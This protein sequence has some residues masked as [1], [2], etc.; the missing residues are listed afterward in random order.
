MRPQV[1]AGLI[2]SFFFLLLLLLLLLLLP[3]FHRITHHN[4]A[5]FHQNRPCPPLL[6]CN[7]RI[8]L[9]LAPCIH[10]A[11]APAVAWTFFIKQP[12]ANNAAIQVSLATTHRF[13]LMGIYTPPSAIVYAC[14]PCIW[15][16]PTCMHYLMLRKFWSLKAIF[17]ILTSFTWIAALP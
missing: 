15:S 1:H 3:Q 2:L 14:Y 17:F 10:H 6:V 13:Q 12:T 8:R 4:R 5:Y 16:L 9:N 7:Y 11:Y